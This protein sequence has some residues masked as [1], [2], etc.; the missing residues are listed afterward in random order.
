MG[1]PGPVV[2]PTLP[3]SGPK[4]G[5]YLPNLGPF[6]DCRTL[7]GLAR[8]AESAG[9]DGFFLWDTIL[10][11]LT[12]P[13]DVV[14]PWVVLAA[15]AVSTHRINIGTLVTPLSR[16]RPWKV[17][18]EVVTLDQLSDGRV[19]FGAGLGGPADAE[20]AAFGEV[21]DDRERAERLDSGLAMLDALWSGAAMTIAVDES[22]AKIPGFR[23]LPRQSPRPP[24]WV[25]GWWPNKP[26]MRRAARWDGIFAQ[27]RDGVCP[28]PH[29]IGQ[30]TSYARAHRNRPGHFDV[31]TSGTTPNDPAAAWNQLRPYASAGLTWWL[32]EAAPG[33]RFSV[34]DM[35]QRILAGPPRDTSR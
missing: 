10:G 11:D 30:V 32:E 2:D 19:I 31:V 1:E 7:I 35:R 17:A 15:V 5:V 14:D 29:D 13:V 4:C 20:F 28:T 12:S 16:R 23:P 33:Q 21:S 24:I 25:G 3:V 26:P 34:R 9:W 18:R 27:L 6:G 8:D 22:I